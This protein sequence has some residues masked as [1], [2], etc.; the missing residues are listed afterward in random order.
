MDQ[1][2]AEASRLRAS[3]TPLQQNET[4]IMTFINK[5]AAKQRRAQVNRMAGVA[6][7]QEALRSY[8]ASKKKQRRRAS[9]HQAMRKKKPGQQKTCLTLME[10][11]RPFP[12]ITQQLCFY[13]KQ[14]TFNSLVGR[15]LEANRKWPSDYKK[16]TTRPQTSILLFIMRNIQRLTLISDAT[17]EFPKNAN[18]SFKVR[19][20]ERLSL[21]GDQ[22]YA[23]LMSLTV[24]DQRQSG[25]A[26]RD[27][28]GSSYNCHLFQ[29][30]VLDSKIYHRGV[31]TGQFQD[32]G[33]LSEI[34]RD[35][36]F[37]TTCHVWQPV[38]ET[39]DARSAQQKHAATHV[40]TKVR[41][42]A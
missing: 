4:G 37:E 29:H 41:L 15:S 12:N 36:E 2:Q 11:A 21:P 42:D 20:P 33:V 10:L 38:L 30:D 6:C 39:S 24:S 18:S 14:S 27:R 32:Q 1:I 40:R 26:W 9:R 22:W 19:L 13:P 34:G 3:Y 17:N 25:V 23:T 35:K 8:T 5:K 7:G 16:R 28:D 31:S